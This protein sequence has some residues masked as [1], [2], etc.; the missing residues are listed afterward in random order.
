MDFNDILICRW[1]TLK[2]A[3]LLVVYYVNIDYV[4]IISLELEHT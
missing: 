2:E 4:F 3:R 1:D